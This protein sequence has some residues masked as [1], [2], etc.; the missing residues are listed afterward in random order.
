MKKATRMDEIDA[1][2][3]KFEPVTPNDEFY[4]DFKNLRGDFQERDVMRILNVTKPDGHYRFNYQPNRSNK[5]L[6]FLAGM[7]GSGKTSELAKYAQLL[8]SP[9]CFFVVTC[10]VD[11]ELDMDNVQ[12][13]DILVFQLEKLLQKAAEVDLSI[14][15]DILDS[16]NEWF[17]ERVKEINRSLKAEGSAELEVGNENPFSV[18]GLLGKLLGVTTKLKLGLSG[19]YER[20]VAIRT[21]I[22]NRFPD[23]SIKFNTFIE[24]TNEQL[25]REGKGQEVL[26]IVDGLEKTM[27]ATTRRAIIMDESNRIR[28]IKANTIFTLPIE[29]MKEEQHIRNFSEIITFP[30]IKIIDR[31]G[32]TVQEAIERFEEFIC[33]RVAPEL[34]DSLETIHLAIRYSGGS[35]RQL[36]RIIEQAGW[37]ADTAV[38]QITNENMRRAIDK[39]GNAT[40]RYLEPTDFDILKSLKTDLDAGNPIGFNSSIQNLLEKEIIFEYNDGTYKRVNPLLEVSRLYQHRVVGEA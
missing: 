16:M 19:S 25:R 7:R 23:F 33:K 8:H 14:S 4:V 9:G 35:P 31:D 21:T 17:Q 15:D 26:F 40:A 30:F 24:Q 36:L 32:S 5:T 3:N 13:M 29:L 27:S 34:F 37:Q 20:A 6:L 11:E 2:V 12:Y 22:K 18:A 28:Q 10:N 38:G 39:L 1:A